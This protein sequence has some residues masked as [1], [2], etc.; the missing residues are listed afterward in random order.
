MPP[1]ETEN[2][3]SLRCR[4]DPAAQS[5]LWTYDE[6]NKVGLT[7]KDIMHIDAEEEQ[8][9][10]VHSGSRHKFDAYQRRPIRHEQKQEER[11]WKKFRIDPGNYVFFLSDMLGS[12]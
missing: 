7:T 2:G 5:S 9:V 10:V 8:V 6:E 4:K 12:I 11:K 3:A 1:D